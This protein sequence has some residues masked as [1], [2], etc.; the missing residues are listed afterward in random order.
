VPAP[1]AV[2]VVSWNTRD[3]LAACLASLRDDHAAG[4]ADVWVVDNA[5]TDGSAELVRDAFGWARLVEAGGNLGYG[6]AVNL[7]A[8]QV[9]AGSW[10][11]PANSDLVFERGALQALLD[12]GERH[13]GAGVFAP[14]LVLPDG[15]TQ[16]SVHPFPT[17]PRLAAFNLGLQGV[18]PG[19][20]DRLL[21]EG[22]WTPERERPVDWAH[23]AFLLVRRAA[24]DAVGGFDDTQWLYAEDLDLGWRLRQQGWPTVYVPAARVRHAVSAATSAAFGEDRVAR[25]QARTYAWMLRRRGPAR[26]RAA[27]GMNLAGAAARAVLTRGPRRAAARRWVAIHRSGLLPAGELRDLR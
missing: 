6:P 22:H 14:R 12:A 13:R 15:A 20:G 24:W 3:L 5:S 4:V 9:A 23:G 7:A 25:A 2:I 18:L 19:L 8:R 27:A 17:L 10:I 21:L 26:M 11:A 1:V 16:H